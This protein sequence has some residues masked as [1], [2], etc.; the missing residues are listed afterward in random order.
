MFDVITGPDKEILRT[1]CKPV[2]D[3]DQKLENIVREM[4]ETMLAPHGK[5]E[6]TGVGLAAPQVDIDARII[7]ITLHIGDSTEK[8]KKILPMINPEILELSENTVILEEGCLSLPGIFGKVSRP[9]KVRARWQNLQGHW[10]E[11]KLGDWDARIF[12]H[13]YDHLEGILFTDYLKKS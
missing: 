10:C 4:E 11:K 7:L 6:I 5:D 1:V 2:E 13:E 12:L 9:A 8:E 3:F